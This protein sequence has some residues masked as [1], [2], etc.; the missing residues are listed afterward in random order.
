ML[1][2]RPFGF[3]QA[4]CFVLLA[5][6]GSLGAWAAPAGADTLNVFLYEKT[7]SDADANAIGVEVNLQDVAGG[8]ILTATIRDLPSLTLGEGDILALWFDVNSA[9][10]LANV[11]HSAP[12]EPSDLNVTGFVKNHNMVGSAPFGGGPNINGMPGEFSATTQKYDVAIRF[13]TNGMGVDYY[14]TVSLKLTNL[15]V[16]DFEQSRFA[17]RVTSI[18]EDNEGSGKYAGIGETPPIVPTP[19]AAMG[20]LALL[21]ALA[22][23]RRRHAD[24]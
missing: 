17:A 5:I 11:N 23:M 7:N 18:G 10:N 12:Y 20:G 8:V 21:G 24:A 9:V 14:P 13:G 6:I 3:A 2:L 16:A 19:T 1:C 15:T 4:R 22:L